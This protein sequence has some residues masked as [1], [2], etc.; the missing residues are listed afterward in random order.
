MRKYL[1][2]LL[3]AV[4]ILLVMAA[5]A[6]AQG[7]GFDEGVGGSDPQ[8]GQT[9]KSRAP[10]VNPPQGEP[11]ATRRA[12]TAHEHDTSDRSTGFGERVDAQQG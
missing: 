5:P 11:G 12:P 6:F 2:A 8:P 1:A 3:V 4:G 10:Q 9:E 7:E